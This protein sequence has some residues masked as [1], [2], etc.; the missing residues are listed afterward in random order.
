MVFSIKKSNNQ[1]KINRIGTH[2]PYEEK[3]IMKCALN[4][5]WLGNN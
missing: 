3:K 5:D 1:L 4:V 2:K